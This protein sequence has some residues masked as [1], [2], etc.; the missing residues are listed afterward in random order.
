M[1]RGPKA[2]VLELT[3]AERAELQRLLRRRGVGQALGQRIRVVLACAEPGATNLGVAT[4]LGVSRQTVAT[5]RRRFAEHRL[6]GLV[7]AP[8]SGAPR[9]IGDEAVERL[10]ALT[11]EEAPRNA[12]HWSTRSMARR[13]GMS[14]TAVSRIWRAFGLR[15]HR[16][17]TFKLSSDPAFVQKVR[18]IIGLYLA[19]PERA[20]VLCVDE[21]PQIQAAQGTAPTF[22]ARPGQL[23]R[24]PHDYRRHGTLDLFAALDVRAGTVIGVCER[25]H[26][27]IEFR[28]FLDRVE[29]AVPPGL[30]VHL[31]LDSLKTHKTRLIHDWLLKRPHF[32][33]HFTPTSA[34]WLNL[35]E[36]W[37]ALLS[38]RRLE[39]G[40]FTS[41]GEL[42]AAIHAY[43][44]ETN[45]DPKPFVWTK[46]ADDIL[47]SVARFCQRTSNSDH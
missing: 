17:E 21:K 40:S 41:T 47:A 26:R 12:T 33:L 15:P 42:E 20:L 34:S 1:S 35:V 22:P 39:R 38:R 27:S 31:V 4:A 37:F 30:E 23:E 18:D 28:A 29:R 19:P 44:T 16:A 36:C 3:A 10:V 8:R 43:I 25:R 24:R 11:L 46:N 5:W 9:S 7:D 2:L 32:H 13:A 45:A 14:Q 6:E